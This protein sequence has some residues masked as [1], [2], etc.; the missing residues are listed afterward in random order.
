VATTV[1]TRV[2]PG[3]VVSSAGP[4]PSA[5][6]ATSI[7]AVAGPVAAGAMPVPVPL[8]R[9]PIAAGP[10]L[11]VVVESLTGFAEASPQ[12]GP[13]TTLG[14]PPAGVTEMTGPD[15]EPTVASW[16]A[17]DPPPATASPPPPPSPEELAA[18]LFDPL[19]RRIKTEL[20]L[21]RERR[22]ALTDLRH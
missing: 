12:T 10:A 1:G 3:P 11:P 17:D 4:G 18:Q 14:A 6:A 15:D 21:D 8:Q 16:R 9:L 2:A 22:G 13:A 20:R 7:P 19:V 5:M